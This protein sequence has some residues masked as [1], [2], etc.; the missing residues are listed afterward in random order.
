MQSIVTLLGQYFCLFNNKVT[1]KELYISNTSI[2]FMT[3]KTKEIMFLASLMM[4]IAACSTPKNI[5]YMEDSSNHNVIRNAP[6]E[7]TVQQGDRL[8]IFVK[9]KDEVLTQHFNISLPNMQNVLTYTVNNRGEIDFPMLGAIHLAGLTRNQAAETIKNRL[10]SEYGTKDAVVT[11]DFTNLKISVLGEVN[12]PGT[13]SIDNDNI[14]I[15]E[16]MGKAGDMTIY[17]KR[18]SVRVVRRQGDETK[19]YVLNLASAQET[20]QSPA[21]YLQQNDIVY[22][23]ANKTRQRQATLNGNTLQSTSFWVSIASL[24][25]TIAVLVF[26]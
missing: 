17:G 20:M 22:V 13:I 1:K 18:D 24:L 8:A 7:I 26:K 3:R 2:T 15:Y 9:S 6:D 25:T 10:I 11:L 21:Y 23:P 14:N 4:L 16:A 19:I 12:K 5:N